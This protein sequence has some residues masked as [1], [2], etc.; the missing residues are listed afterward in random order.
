MAIST[1]NSSIDGFCFEPQDSN[2]LLS[3][4]AATIWFLYPNQFR[5][6]LEALS[7]FVFDEV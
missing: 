7:P 1:R 5:Q 4:A 6:R 3:A 2:E